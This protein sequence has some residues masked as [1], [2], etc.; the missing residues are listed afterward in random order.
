[1]PRFCPGVCA[2][3]RP[4]V[5]KAAVFLVPRFCPGLP[6]RAPHTPYALGA[7]SER[8]ARAIT[9]VTAASGDRLSHPQLQTGARGI[10]A[11]ILRTGCSQVRA[12][13]PPLSDQITESGDVVRSIQWPAE[14]HNSQIS[15][16]TDDW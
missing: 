2:T 1:M 9:G 6:H 4:A 11:T 15:T 16:R 8:C 14:S 12:T 10:A 13:L 7:R 3:V 5:L